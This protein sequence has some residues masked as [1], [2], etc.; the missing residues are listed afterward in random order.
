[1]ISCIY[2]QIMLSHIFKIPDLISNVEKITR[3]VSHYLS[4]KFIRWYSDD[5]HYINNNSNNTLARQFI[6]AESAKG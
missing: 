1:M 3:F 4:R 5:P 2:T 6:F